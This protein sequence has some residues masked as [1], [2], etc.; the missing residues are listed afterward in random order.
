M[1][2]VYAVNT[3]ELLHINEFEPV[4]SDSKS[5]K[6]KAPLVGFDAEH[7]IIKNWK[8]IIWKY[9]FFQNFFEILWL[10][11]KAISLERNQINQS[12]KSIY[13]YLHSFRVI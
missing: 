8:R 9:T 13:Q 1:E 2:S 4:E 7:F 10:N 3:L 6:M 11:G 12:L 5:Q